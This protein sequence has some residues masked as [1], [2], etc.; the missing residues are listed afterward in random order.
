M[1]NFK[2]APALKKMPRLV[3]APNAGQSGGLSI[4][5]VIRAIGH[6]GILTGL[7][8]DEMES[9]T[10]AAA[11]SLDPNP[12]NVHQPSTAMDMLRST[13]AQAGQKREHTPLEKVVTGE[14]QTPQAPSVAGDMAASAASGA[15]RGTA[16]TAML[17]ITT[18][19]AA[20]GLS[21]WLSYKLVDFLTQHNDLVGAPVPTEEQREALKKAMTEQN[22]PLDR[23]QDAVRGFMDENL[24][25]PKTTAGKYSK[26]AFEFVPGAIALGGGNLL[27]NAVKYGVV[28]G[29]ASEAAGQATEGTNLEPFARLVGALLGSGII[30]AG[31]RLITPL[32][33]SAERQ[34]M[35]QTLRNEGIE[36]TGGAGVWQRQLTQRR[37][38]PWWSSGEEIQQNAR[39]P[40]HAR[41]TFSCRH[42][43]EPRHA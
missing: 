20:G 15:A 19:R 16:E 28:P 34:M 1:S 5:D 7:Y 9:G 25:A 36:L 35:N 17:P 14:P 4:D 37:K 23:A 38:R 30:P 10:G 26:T 33:V 43:R 12:E 3:A 22:G 2:E 39:R 42:R 29:F 32:P 18:T 41:G 6:G 13:G 27:M 21:D 31:E 40:T 11:S 24:Y 8:A